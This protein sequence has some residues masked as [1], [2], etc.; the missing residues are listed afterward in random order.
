M[1]T[2]PNATWFPISSFWRGNVSLKMPDHPWNPTS[3]LW[4]GN[5][6]QKCQIILE[7][8][9]QIIFEIV[10]QIIWNVV[11]LMQGLHVATKRPFWKHPRRMGLGGILLAVS[12]G[13]MLIGGSGGCLDALFLHLENSPA[14]YWPL[15]FNHLESGREL[16]NRPKSAEILALVTFQQLMASFR[17][18]GVFLSCGGSGCSQPSSPKGDPSLHLRWYYC[19]NNSLANMF[20][21]RPGAHYIKLCNDAK[22]ILLYINM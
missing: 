7:I 19:T 5:V 13:F 15:N 2:R 1:W 20:M 17:T 9:F 22:I 16:F 11:K 3:S 6:L 4:R 14:P 12:P 18:W 10:F 8:I 21:Y